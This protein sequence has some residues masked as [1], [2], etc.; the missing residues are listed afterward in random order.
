VYRLRYLKSGKD[1]QGL[2]REV[3]DDDDDDDDN[4]NG[5]RSGSTLYFRGTEST[6]ND[7]SAS[8]SRLYM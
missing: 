5:C 3:H 1:P 6:K 4:E 8:T 7:I 2:E